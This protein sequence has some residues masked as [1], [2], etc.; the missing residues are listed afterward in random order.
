MACA[1]FGSNFSSS[2]EELQRFSVSSSSLLERTS[3]TQ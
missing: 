3:R 1:F 2:K